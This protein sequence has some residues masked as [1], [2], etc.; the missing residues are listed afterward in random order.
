MSLR[1]HTLTLLK[2]RL[3]VGWKR[4]GGPLSVAEMSVVQVKRWTMGTVGTND[5][6]I[7]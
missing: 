1:R 6:A 4:N 5:L 3:V 7:W 2:Y